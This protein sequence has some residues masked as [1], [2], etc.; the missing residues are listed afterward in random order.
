MHTVQ[1]EEWEKRQVGSW[2]A[3]AAS[4][5]GALG[6]RSFFVE[7]AIDEPT[8]TGDGILGSEID[9]GVRARLSARIELSR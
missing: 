6:R 1:E 3:A 7:Y 4:G 5:G 8:A 9:R 2:A